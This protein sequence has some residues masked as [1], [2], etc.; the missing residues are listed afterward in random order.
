VIVVACPTQAE[1]SLLAGAMRCPH[2]AGALRPHGHARTR[3][4]RGLGA[5]TVR[6]TPRRARCADCLK[7]CVLLPGALCARRADST[8]VIAR[9]LA[10]KA[11]GAGFRTIA[12]RLGRPAST[13]RRWLRRAPRC[14]TE[15]LY[16]RAVQQCARI[17]RELL[18]DLAPQPSVLGHALNLLAGAALRAHQLFGHT[19]S[20]WSFI[21]AF[22]HGCLLAP[23]LR[24]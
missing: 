16:Q 24:S 23:P 8:E 12:A 13:V 20:P 1:S 2:C 9:A 11:A 6:V 5:D 7:T 19:C 21:G 17:D 10:A 22:S 4:V 14:H 3:T 18:A 15:W